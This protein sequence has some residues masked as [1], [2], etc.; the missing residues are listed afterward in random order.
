MIYWGHFWEPCAPNQYWVIL[1]AMP[2]D[3]VFLINLL[4]SILGARLEERANSTLHQTTCFEFRQPYEP[5]MYSLHQLLR[6]FC[7]S[8]ALTNHQRHPPSH[9][10]H[11]TCSSETWLRPMVNFPPCFTEFNSYPVVFEMFAI[12]HFVYM[13][14]FFLRI[15]YYCRSIISIAPS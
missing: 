7:G 5:Q 3:H 8:K 13:V 10:S 9:L 2:A 12:I 1:I 11:V 4:F 15:P 14:N 6:K